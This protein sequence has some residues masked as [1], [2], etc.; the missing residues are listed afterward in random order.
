MDH[1]LVYSLFLLFLSSLSNTVLNPCSHLQSN[2]VPILPDD[3]HQ[4]ARCWGYWWGISLLDIKADCILRV[5]CRGS[6]LS[7]FVSLCGWRGWEDSLSPEIFC[8]GKGKKFDVA[9]IGWMGTYE[10]VVKAVARQAKYIAIFLQGFMHHLIARTTSRK[11]SSTLYRFLAEDS[12]YLIL[13]SLAKLSA[14]SLEIYRP[15]FAQDYTHNP[16]TTDT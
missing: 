9:I 1:S 4:L 7:Y 14:S 5:R 12:M 3:L 16:A 8:S 6:C 15:K 13:F 2:I 10:M 11:A